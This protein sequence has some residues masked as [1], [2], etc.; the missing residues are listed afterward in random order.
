MAVLKHPGQVADLAKLAKTANGGAAMLMHHDGR[1][2]R[3][4]A[5]AGWTTT[6]W[7]G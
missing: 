4:R 1:V 6:G 2:A 5:E 7:P 3:R